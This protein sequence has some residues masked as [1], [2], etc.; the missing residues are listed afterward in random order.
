M[1]PTLKMEELQLHRD[2]TWFVMSYLPFHNMI[3]FDEMSLSRL[4]I[5][6]LKQEEGNVKV[7]FKKKKL[8]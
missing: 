1:K 6:N 3:L 2:V 4:L 7:K 8:F 5:W